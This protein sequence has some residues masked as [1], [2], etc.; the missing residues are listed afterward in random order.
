MRF[1]GDY[2]QESSFDMADLLL[3]G[4]RDKEDIDI[5]IIS[6]R[7]IGKDNAEKGTARSIDPQHRESASRAEARRNAKKCEFEKTKALDIMPSDLQPPR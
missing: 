5:E 2:D 6:K 1:A 7:D 4:K 3:S